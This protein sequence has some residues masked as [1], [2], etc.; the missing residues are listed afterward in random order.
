MKDIFDE[1]QL[2]DLKL[3]SRII[4][5]GAWERETEDGGYLT[6]AVFDRYEKMASSGVGLIL[7]EMFA[8]DHKDRFFD[9][10]ANMNY[11]GFVKDYKQLTDICHN[12]NVPILGQLAFFYYDDG[13]N[14]KAEP[15]DLTI[16]G[17][18]KLQ[19]EVIMAAKKFSFAGFDGIQINMGNNFYLSRFT[20]P[21]FNQRTDDYGGNTL[22][23][24]RIVLEIIKLIKKTIGF[25][26]SCRINIEDVRKGGLTQEESMKMAKLLAENGADSIQITGRTISM[27]YDAAEKHVF[28]DYADKLSQEVDIPVILAGNLRDMKTMNDILNSS[29]VEF[30]SLSKPFVAQADFLADWKKNGEGTSRC[31]G[32]NNCYSKKESRCFQYDD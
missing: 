24:M 13:D 32:C 21:Y 25:H 20:N 23:R 9:Y 3:N 2:N 16:E 28:Q 11:K 18:R 6:P 1:C 31:K 15:N 30:M 8:L 10:S 22:N 5:T 14:Q 27:E 12:F 17:I 26:V 19:A 7:S 4:R 29:H